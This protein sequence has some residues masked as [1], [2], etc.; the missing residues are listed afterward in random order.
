MKPGET[1]LL[2][3]DWWNGNRTI[4]ADADLTGVICGL[5]LGTTAPHIYRALLE[6]IA[7]GNRRIIDNF[8]EHG[9]PMSEIVACGGIAS[10]SP[11]LMQ[12]FADVERARGAGSRLQRDPRPWFGAVRRRGGRSVRGHRQRRG[13]DQAPHGPHVLPRIRRRTRP[14]SRCMG[15]TAGLYELLGR[16]RSELLHELKRLRTERSAA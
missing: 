16:E 10:A 8:S 15:S 6:S 5:T 12:L 11:L 14:T 9:L 2:A 3:L 13:G 1:G 4:L 7:L